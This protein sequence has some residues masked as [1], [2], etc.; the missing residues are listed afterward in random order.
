LEG[1][2]QVEDHLRRSSKEVRISFFDGSAPNARRTQI[3]DLEQ[4]VVSPPKTRRRVS[5]QRKKAATNGLTA[6]KP[7]R[8]WIITVGLVMIVAFNFLM[9]EIATSPR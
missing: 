2:R 4:L 1:I 9:I 8:W 3:A 5:V 6:A 7:R